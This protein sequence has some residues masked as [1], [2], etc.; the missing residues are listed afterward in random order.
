MIRSVTNSLQLS[1][2]A[3]GDILIGGEKASF[4]TIEQPETLMYTERDELSI[5]FIGAF[6]T[7]YCLQ[8][9]SLPK[10]LPLMKVQ[11]SPSLA[12]LE[13]VLCMQ[14]F[15]ISDT[16]ICRGIIIERDNGTKQTLGQCRI[17]MDR[18]QAYNNPSHICF[19]SATPRQCEAHGLREAL[20]VVATT[21]TKDHNHQED[22][23]TC[24]E[25]RG[26]LKF[27]TGFKTIKLEHILKNK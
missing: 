8:N 27:C 23:W 19:A 16:M 24:C 25:M 5:S 9:Y 13:R 26:I 10:G 7:G 3:D 18:I 11:T 17:G 12:S 21:V 4:W 14:V 2:E 22:G 20:E 1:T 6:S 15:Y